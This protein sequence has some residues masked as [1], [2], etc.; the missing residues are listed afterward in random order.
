MLNLDI[1]RVF[2]SGTGSSVGKFLLTLGI[3]QELS[4]SGLSVS[5]VIS[6]P[7]LQQAAILRRL[8]NRYV[9]CIDSFLLSG[10]Q[11]QEIL[12][13][14]GIGSDLVLIVGANGI[15]DRG[16]LGQSRGSDAE[17]ALL[18][19][20]PVIL[21]VPV[22]GV[23][24]TV[25]PIIQGIQSFHAEKVIEG[26][27]LNWVADGS[28]EFYQ[29]LFS[30][31][32]LPELLG[33]IPGIQHDNPLP[34]KL[35]SEK[36]NRTSLPR[37]FYLDLSKMIES[38]MKLDRFIKVAK[39]A[40]PV[41]LRDFSYRQATKKA[42]RLAVAEDSCFHILFQDNLAM[43]KYHGID[44]VSFSPLADFDLPKNVGGVYIPG[45]YL[46]DY[47][48]ELE[49]NESIRHSIAQLVKG[50]GVLIS[51]GS[52]TA[53]LC[54]QYEFGSE[55]RVCTGVGII[56]G[57][58]QSQDSTPLSMETVTIEET[59]LG[60]PGEIIRGIG[61][62]EW[63]LTEISPVMKTARS[64]FAGN[65]AQPD[66]YSPVAQSFCTFSFMHLGSNPSSARRLAEAVSLVGG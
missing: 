46:A 57:K 32:D 29:D 28:E 42:G 44:I 14:A 64:S 15:Y 25:V 62:N 61:T 6:G 21:V 26:V 1:P 4:H 41:A 10:S 39:G 9:R 45:G 23:G 12:Y 31:Y 18:S 66:G 43:L 3:V 34:D 50:G 60:P 5:C 58:A 63:Q 56:P 36:E 24:T 53:Y 16:L 48:E 22:Q 13:H 2:I 55:G 38:G 37:Q 17:L 8:T 52:G 30:N 20:T 27:L 49:R 59:I 7:Q 40:S 54:E 33:C 19:S 11:N 51:E 65:R 47:G 35:L